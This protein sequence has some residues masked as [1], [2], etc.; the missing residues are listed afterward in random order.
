MAQ[1]I[2]QKLSDGFHTLFPEYAK[3]LDAAKSHEQIETL[4]SRFVLEC[5]QN[6]DKALAK[7]NLPAQNTDQTCPV[8]LLPDVYERLINARDDAIKNELTILMDGLQRLKDYEKNAEAMS[9]A[10]LMA[11]CIAVGLTATTIALSEVAVGATVE[12]AAL[13]GVLAATPAV[14]V[15]I[16]ALIIIAIIIPI[17]YFM[18]KP[19]ACFALLINELDKELYFKGECNIHGKP[20]LITPRI[21]A[22]RTI[23]KNRYAAG[24]LI[25]TVKHDGA[26]IGTRYGCTYKYGDD[27]L[28]LGMQCPLTDPKNNCYCGFDEEACTAAEKTDQQNVLYDE[29]TKGKLKQSIRCN[30]H[31]GDVAYF[32]ARAYFV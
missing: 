32:I 22:M 25:A 29:K 4:Y 17:L 30:S 16:V 9:A 1:A 5:Q 12:A 19:A 28:A 21:P 15:A 10:I 6:L 8:L 23:G 18:F 26:L 3:E 24:G 7:S 14:I 20:K 31:T 11:G 13:A 27:V 2:N